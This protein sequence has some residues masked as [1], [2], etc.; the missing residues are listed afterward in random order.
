MNLCM[1]KRM[2]TTDSELFA[3]KSI[4]RSQK[5]DKRA[6]KNYGR[7]VSYGYSDC[8][9]VWDAPEEPFLPPRNSAHS[10]RNVFTS[11]K[12]SELRLKKKWAHFN[13]FGQ[14]A[15]KESG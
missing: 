15:K 4:T 11:V 7:S 13:T 1:L 9:F 5:F 14:R 6:P 12:R 10:A 3:R 8:D 2:E